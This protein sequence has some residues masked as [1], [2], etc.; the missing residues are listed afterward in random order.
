VLFFVAGVPVDFIW[1]SHRAE[2]PGGQPPRGPQRPVAAT[3]ATRAGQQLEQSI[4]GNGIV[5]TWLELVQ[6]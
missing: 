1:Y 3:Q 4:W 6:T 2:L 5:A